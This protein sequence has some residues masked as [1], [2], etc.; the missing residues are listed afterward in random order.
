M[1]NKAFRIGILIFGGLLSIY[2][3]GCGKTGKNGSETEPNNTSE[4]IVTATPTVAE[5]L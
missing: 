4:V 5:V 3:P 2:M 1:K